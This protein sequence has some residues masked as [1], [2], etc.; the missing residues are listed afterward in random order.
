MSRILE[1]IFI[2]FMENHETEDNEN[3]RRSNERALSYFAGIAATDRTDAE[4]VL[5]GL[6]YEYEK[7][8]FMNGFLYAL[9][10][11]SGALA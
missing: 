6:G 5:T 2:D 9:R 8:G 3:V 11:I 4:D 1:E 7:Q 10:F